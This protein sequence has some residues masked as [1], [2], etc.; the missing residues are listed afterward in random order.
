MSGTALSGGSQYVES[1]GTAIGE[2][3]A[4]GGT[5]IVITGGTASGV[6]FTGTS[7]TLEGST[8][9]PA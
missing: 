7:G 5:E 1:A 2:T 4:S 6:T 3:I 9:L 8:S